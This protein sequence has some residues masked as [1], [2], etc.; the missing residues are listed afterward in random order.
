MRLS[1][2]M[3]VATFELKS[4]TKTVFVPSSEGVVTSVITEKEYNNIIESSP[5]FRR[6]GGSETAAKCYTEAGFKV[7]RLTSKTQLVM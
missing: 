1:I 3:S 2:T 4:N 5:Y 6:L 7:Y